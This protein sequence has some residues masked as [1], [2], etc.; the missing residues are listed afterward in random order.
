MGPWDRF[1]QCGTS[2]IGPCADDGGATRV[3]SIRGRLAWRRLGIR[4][5]RAHPCA[6]LP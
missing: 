5:R 6:L 4:L 3:A 1:K 2:M